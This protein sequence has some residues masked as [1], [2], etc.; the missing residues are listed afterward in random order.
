VTCLW[1][2][3]GDS[4]DLGHARPCLGKHRDRGPSLVMEV[5][6]GEAA[7]CITSFHF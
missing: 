1:L 4:C 2:W 3:P 6:F 7:A 5:Q